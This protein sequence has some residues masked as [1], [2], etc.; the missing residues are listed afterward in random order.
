MHESDT[1]DQFDATL[2]DHLQYYNASD[3][4]HERVRA[5]IDAE[6][7]R[8]PA[9]RATRGGADARRWKTLA[10]AAS[11]LLAVVGTHDVWSHLPSG[12]A[13]NAALTREL[14]AGH[15]RSLKSGHLVDVEST[16]RHT[17][18]PWFDGK[19]DFSPPVFDFAADSFPL[20]GGRVDHVG[21]QST[22]AMVF[23]RGQHTINLFVW[24]ADS[25]D[26]APVAD[27]YNGYNVV[28]WRRNRMR[29]A[30]V[31]SVTAASLMH[32]AA[33]YAARDS[34]ATAPL[35]P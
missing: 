20:V 10:L 25:A 18:K 31:S 24:P 26:S 21:N 35:S 19:L 14:I 28:T 22:S 11:L 7:P 9:A 34:I 17:V 33:L 13:P 4:L 15:I 16:D 1:R 6:S 12:T 30:A 5:L 2:R 3:A 32:F 29:F 8:G 23:M 27:G